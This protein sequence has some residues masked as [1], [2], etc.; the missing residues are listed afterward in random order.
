MLKVDHLEKSFGTKQVLHQISFEIK[1]GHIVGLIGANGAGKTTIMK[2][3]LGITSFTGKI[4]FNG[5]KITADDHRALERV[6]ALIEYPGL[7]PYLT[8]REQ[9]TLFSRGDQPRN[10]VNRI[11]EDLGISSYADIKTSKYSLG[12]RQKLGIALAFVNNP[13]LVILDEPMNGID[14][15]ATME[16]RDLILKKKEQGVTFLISSHILSELQKIA[17]EVTII[18][19]GRLVLNSTMQDILSKSSKYLLLDT[20]QNPVAEK[21]LLQ[22]G[23]E[24]FTDKHLLKIK[25]PQNSSINEM[26]KV[27]WTQN[28]LIKNISETQGDLED[29]L[30]D[31]L[32]KSPQESLEV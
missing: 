8:G 5:L 20:N 23:Y 27:L 2:S 9:L 10:K 14:P 15:K 30:L 17:D 12:M 22:N 13:E 28:I 4:V 18:D 31:V 25:R 6:G 1:R 19:H 21:V 16:L 29:S 3:I 11:I 7:Y 24:V 26:L 32:K